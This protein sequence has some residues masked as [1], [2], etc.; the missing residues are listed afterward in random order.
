MQTQSI[1]Q[2]WGT[3]IS[4]PP[5]ASPKKAGVRRQKLQT[6]GQVAVACARLYREARAGDISVQDATRLASILAVLGRMLSDAELQAVTDRLD[7][8]EGH[9]VK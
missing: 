3:G 2:P 9:T 5:P 1:H 7:R 4:P 6:P 8:L